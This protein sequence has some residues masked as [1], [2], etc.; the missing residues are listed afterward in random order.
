MIALQMRY[1]VLISNGIEM[2]HYYMNS[3]HSRRMAFE[4]ASNDI[5]ETH[6]SGWKVLAIVTG[7]HEVFSSQDFLS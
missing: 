7:Q 4:S 1:T 6:G 3:S 2:E 5:L